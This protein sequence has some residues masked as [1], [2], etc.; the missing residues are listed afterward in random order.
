MSTYMKR[1][2]IE[3][4]IISA[5][6]CGLKEVM[7]QLGNGL[8][9]RAPQL[10]RDHDVELAF[11]V[12]PAYRGCFGPDIEYVNMS[13]LSKHWLKHVGCGQVDLFHAP[14]QYCTLKHVAGARH[15]LLT[16]HD[17]NFMYEKHGARLQRGIRRLQWRLDHADSLSFISRFAQEDT[18]TYFKLGVP[19]R[20]IYNGVTDLTQ[21]AASAPSGILPELPERFFF[22]VSSLYPKKNVHLLVEMMKYLPDEH[23]VIAGTWQN[24]EYGRSLQQSIADAPHHN[25][26]TLDRISEEQ[27]AV[28]YS[29]CR[30]FMFPSLCEGFGLPPIEA[31]K[32]GKPAFLSTLTSLP[33]VGG[34]VAFYWPDLTPEAMAT[35]VHRSM[36]AAD[37][38][39]TMAD[40]LRAHASQFTWDRSI[41]G[42]IA[43]YLDILNS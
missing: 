34:D 6:Y 12:P 1:I 32:F 16:I 5:P 28:L 24:D 35:E 20:I 33:E 3:A 9:A 7:I 10:R 17:I 21:L 8:A 25:I 19:Q 37:A 30:A 43:Y 38:D 36:A 14:H 15:T 31:M 40:R 39:P 13:G 26:T 4:N 2:L 42:Y 27:K 22:H 11:V 23:L 18:A 29:R 41:T